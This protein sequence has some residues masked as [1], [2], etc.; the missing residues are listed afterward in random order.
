MNIRKLIES[1][2]PIDKIAKKV[3]EAGFPGEGKKDKPEG[4]D[5][6]AEAKKKGLISAGFGK[7]KDKSGKV[8]AKTVDG[9][10][11]DIDPSESGED[12]DEET[13]SPKLP[14]EM[15]DDADE[16]EGDKEEDSPDDSEAKELASKLHE[17]EDD[18]GNSFTYDA[19]T[20][21]L[22]S[23]NPEALSNLMA[24]PEA[25]EFIQSN[26]INVPGQSGD[27]ESVDGNNPGE[28]GG[29]GDPNSEGHSDIQDDAGS[30]IPGTASPDEFDTE[31]FDYW[32]EENPEDGEAIESALGSDHI[33][34]V[35][36]EL[37]P[38]AYQSLAHIIQNISPESSS[39]G[40]NGTSINTYNLKGI[41]VVTHTDFGHTA[42]HV[43]VKDVD[44]VLKRIGGTSTPDEEDNDQ[45]E[46]DLGN[47]DDDSDL[48]G[49]PSNQEDSEETEFNSMKDKKLG[50]LP[51]EE[52]D[53]Y[54]DEYE[55]S[56]KALG[57]SDKPK[58]SDLSVAPPGW[59]K[60]DWE[61][62]DDFDREANYM[63]RDIEN[64]SY[65]DDFTTDA[66]D[67]FKKAN[68]K[69]AAQ[70]ADIYGDDASYVGT[71]DSMVSDALQGA[72]NDHGDEVG[73]SGDVKA[74]N[75][76]GTTFL[77]VKGDDGKN[78]IFIREQDMPKVHSEY[79]SA[80][81]NTYKP[82]DKEADDLKGKL[83]DLDNDK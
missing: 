21:T 5:A 43:K 80:K 37:S 62:L 55:A 50:D 56:Q 49:N 8:V 17:L 71:E 11:V 6:S 31:A 78:K 19:E 58:V 12:N 39:Q 77:V 44:K 65:P 67:N 32:K 24:N 57:P 83:D 59:D 53:D 69:A 61:D 35:D 81:K 60:D 2:L 76:F 38:N 29:I 27:G 13:K 72:I 70:I 10:L 46:N 4:D 23:D 64:R 25:A 74:V 16:T 45:L 3:T 54:P 33:A 79:G 73:G 68:P 14:H 7:W 34:V 52:D 75:Y 63:P 41:K 42:M 82:E 9:K 18:D 36:E 1:K 66:F 26:G 22:N 51:D 40:A 28:L 20:N 30:E 47:L 15:D 48:N